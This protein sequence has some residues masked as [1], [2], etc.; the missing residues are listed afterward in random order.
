MIVLPQGEHSGQYYLKLLDDEVTEDDIRNF[1][2]DIKSG[3]AQLIGK[4]AIGRV[5][6][7]FVFGFYRLFK[8]NPVLGGLI[9]KTIFL[10]FIRC[11]CG[12][13]IESAINLILISWITDHSYFVCYLG[14]LFCS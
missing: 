12:R 2:E 4:S 9:S 7:D 8:E 11:F 13:N 6:S 3:K 10:F 5:I 14:R 1:I